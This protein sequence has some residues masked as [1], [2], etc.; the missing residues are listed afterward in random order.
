[1]IN[2]AVKPGWAGG[3]WHTR[4]FEQAL[5]TA[6]YNITDELNADVVVAHSIACYDLKTKSPATYYILIDPPYWPGKS[7]LARFI[8]KQRQDNRSLK[9]RFGRKYIVQ[10][11]LWGAFYILARPRDTLLALNSSGQLDFLNDLQDKN[12]LII[13]NQQD[14][15]CSADI[16]V[17]LA[18]YPDIYYY[19]LPGQHDDYYYNPQ[20]YIDLLPTTL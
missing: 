6:G 10:K 1:M 18:A 13:R 8:E 2:L 20:P 7:I 4:Q 16:K 9:N 12:V 19:E 3:G 15:L 14:Q 5:R 11:I 17:A